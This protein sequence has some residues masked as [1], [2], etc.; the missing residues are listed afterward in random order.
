MPTRAR[1]AGNAIQRNF[2][3][4]N[5]PSK[6][7]PLAKNQNKYSSLMASHL[8]SKKALLNV[9]TSAIGMKALNS[10]CEKPRGLA[11]VEQMIK[12]DEGH[13]LLERLAKTQGGRTILESGN[14]HTLNHLAKIAKA[15]TK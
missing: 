4:R 7:D 15:K 9:S 14:I 11:F 10:L 8:R 2:V 3:A 13:A 1:L 6:F 12:T 5:S